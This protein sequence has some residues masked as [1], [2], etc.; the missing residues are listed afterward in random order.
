[1][2]ESV[3]PVPSL[4][5]ASPA[6]GGHVMT[7]YFQSMLHLFCKLTHLKIPA[8]LQMTTSESLITR[9]RN[10]LVADFLQRPDFTHFIFIDTD[11][12]FNA[13]DIIH[14]LNHCG[15]VGALDCYP[16][17]TGIYPKK[18]FDLGRLRKIFSLPEA[19]GIPDIIL[20]TKALDY[21]VNVKLPKNMPID[22]KTGKPALTGQVQVDK[23]GMVPIDESG[24]G[25]MLI[26][27]SVF[28]RF[29]IESDKPMAERHPEFRRIES[30]M[31]DT[32]SLHVAKCYTWFDT[33]VDPEASEGKGRYLS[34]DWAFCRL[35]KALDIPVVA[36]AAMNLT[37]TGTIDYAGSFNC[38]HASFADIKP[39]A[40]ADSAN[41]S[42]TNKETQSSVPLPNA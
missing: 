22:E 27:R 18:R 40:D 11:I 23:A 42:E 7:G 29:I 31:N 24:T 33:F 6:Y 9:G 38:A 5:V 36:Y 14:M 4:L 16:I 25:M 1:M 35:A 17:V 21:V 19:Q 3:K 13:E 41:T 20:A 2:S 34:E 32:N 37:H 30:Y 12:T 15:P 28:E 10:Y 8:T 26:H 39:I